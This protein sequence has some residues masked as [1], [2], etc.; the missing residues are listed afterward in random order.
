MRAR[1]CLRFLIV[2]TALFLPAF[3]YAQQLEVR[4]CPAARIWSYPAESQ[5]GVQSLLLQNAAVINRSGN[6]IEVTSLDI[7]LL[8]GSVVVDT[9]HIAGGDLKK[10]AA[11]GPQIQA[12]G[13]FQLASF[14]FCGDQLIGKGVALSGP[15]LKP[16][17][18]MLVMAQPFVYRG[19]RDTLRLRVTAKSGTTS[20]N[21][22]ASLAIKSGAVQTKFRFPLTGTWYAGN[23]P[24]FYTAHR[25]ALP[26]EFG[27]DI[28]QLGCNSLSQSGDGTKFSDYYAYGKPVLA[29]ADGRVKAV[30]G[31]IPENPDVLRKPGESS[32]AYGQ[33]IQQMQAEHLEKGT[34]AGNYVLIQ[35]GDEIY[36]LY[37]HL[38]PASITV[39][40]GDTVTAGQT[41]GSLGS[42]GNTTEPH[43]HFQVCDRPDPL[44]CAGLPVNFEGIVLPYA[45]A[46]RPLQSGDIVQSGVSEAA[47]GTT[48]P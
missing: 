4:F 46:P 43:L 22:E 39:R 20:L 48:K 36:S 23:G 1:E 12:A 45:D 15:V 35:S 5:R 37:A 14:Q 2:T 47:P 33:R 26:E 13:L 32:E 11:A 24:T 3:L 21:G 34:A 28:V 8:Q 38:R 18:A 44:N 6:P 31:N 19:T 40:V 16:G 7:E 41:I 30:V 10:V 9:R 25:W 27:F 17:E 29:A 42:S